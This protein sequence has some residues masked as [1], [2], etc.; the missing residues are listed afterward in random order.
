M[1]EILGIA[2]AIVALPFIYNFFANRIR[3]FYAN[4]W[5]PEK[6]FERGFTTLLKDQS[7][8]Y[9][10]MT[11]YVRE[12]C[13]GEMVTSVEVVNTG[14]NFLKALTPSFFASTSD[15]P[16]YRRLKPWAK[17]GETKLE[18]KVDSWNA[19]KCHGRLI[20]ELSPALAPGETC[21]L[22]WGWSAANCWAE[23]VEFIQWDLSHVIYKY[24]GRIIA[25]DCW[26]L[27]APTWIE[28][29]DE[30][31]GKPILQDGA[32]QWSSKFPRIGQRHRLEFTLARLSH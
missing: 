12:D 29:K 5:S 3:K 23:G 8:G 30:T 25:D 21:E 1:L 7:F 4:I 14:K 27:G 32:I 10:D 13:S 20:I 31:L 16:S 9:W 15:M 17:S 26:V 24:S 22:E 2:L 6:Q 28:A 19:E 18:V 11:F